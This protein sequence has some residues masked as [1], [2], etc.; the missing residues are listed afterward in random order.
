MAG[1]SSLPGRLREPRCQHLLKATTPGPSPGTTHRGSWPGPSLVQQAD[2]HTCSSPQPFAQSSPL[3]TRA[4]G[5]LLLPAQ[6]APMGLDT[7]VPHCPQ[8]YSTEPGLPDLGGGCGQSGR[9]EPNILFFP[10]LEK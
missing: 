2:H 1:G 8:A 10:S 3:D 5:K 7:T 6:Q 9:W 4:L